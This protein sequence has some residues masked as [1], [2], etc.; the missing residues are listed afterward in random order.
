MKTIQTL[1]FLLSVGVIVAGCGGAPADAG[2]STASTTP[3]AKAPDVPIN[4]YVEAGAPVTQSADPKTNKLA[5]QTVAMKLGPARPDPFALRNDESE[6]DRAQNTERV[7][8]QMGG[9]SAYFT[10]TTSADEPAAPIPEPQP[11]RRLA[12]VV[13]GD[14]VLALIDMGNNQTYLIR[15]G[16]EI[17]DSEWT[18]ASI[19]MDKAVLKRS[20]SR[21]PHEITVRLE[22]PPINAAGQGGGAFGPGGV[23]GGGGFP[24]GPPGGGGPPPGFGGGAGPGG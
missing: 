18:V 4:Q 8:G 15:P 17:P 1:A 13:V 12:G 19:D 14:S 24:G 7:F 23:P 3:A 21:L 2:A 22:L 16:M 6:F 5:I 9:Y 11:Y 20:G 10:P